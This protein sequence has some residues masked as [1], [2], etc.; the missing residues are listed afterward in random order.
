MTKIEFKVIS[1]L[2]I[3]KVLCNE[4]VWIMR[5]FFFI[6]VK[7]IFVITVL[8]LIQNFSV[9]STHNCSRYFPFLERPEDYVLR[10]RSHLTFSLFTSRA[11]TAFKRGG[12]NAGIPELW[13]FYDLKD[14]IA[15]LEKVQGADFVNPIATERGI[16][17]DWIDKSIRFEVDGKL[18]GR[19]ILLNYEQDLKWNG[20]QV[21]AFIPFMHL[22]SCE[23][24]NFLAKESS[25]EL[26]NLRDGE[27]SQ[28]DRIRR[29]VHK[30]LGFNGEDW[31]K[32]GFGDLDLH[33]RWNHNWD[34]KVR[35]KNIDLNLQVGLLAP[36]GVNSDNAYSSAV[37]FMGNGCW[38]LYFDIVTELVLKQDWIFGFMLGVSHQFSHTRKLRIPVYKEPAIFSALFADVKNDSGKFFKASPYFTLQNL[39]DGV[40]FHVRYTYLRHSQDNWYD[41]RLDK[42][43]ASYLNQEAGNNIGG[44]VLTEEDIYNNICA[45]KSLSLW[46]MHYI[47]L[48]FAYDSRQANNHWVLDPT[49]YAAFDYQF[50]GNGSCKT[51]QLTVGVELHF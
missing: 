18:K 31:N 19:G 10:K 46:R 4:M 7:K 24:F 39:T 41:K 5:S 23:R 8:A 15:S 29:L 35:L 12:G 43:V 1:N 6:Q 34:H 44:Q 9:F 38:A 13:G 50:S 36:T 16:D 47:T 22:D 45:K 30:E 3:L 25:N 42:S 2:V 27:L 51:H 32:T 40:N 20:F 17:N 49:V 48:Q 14:V 37:S 26:Q 33:L 11:S 28:L 21:G